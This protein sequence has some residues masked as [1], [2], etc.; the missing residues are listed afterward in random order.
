MALNADHLAA[1]WAVVETGSYH[2]AAETLFIT[3]SAV[4][5]RIQGLEAALG[6]KVFVRTGRRVHLTEAGRVLSRHCQA[7]RQL[8]ATLWETLAGHDGRLAGRLAVLAD[9][10]EWRGWLL[11]ALADLARTH[12][13]L[14][15]Q[16]TVAEA[17]DPAAS[18][19]AGK[20]DLVV[21]ERPLARRGLADRV[22]GT[23]AY[24]LVARPDITESWP[25]APTAALLQS[26]RGVDFAPEDRL[27]RD[28]LALCLPESD[29]TGF[30]SHFVNSTDGILAW[31]LEGAGYAAL[32]LHLV[33]PHLVSGRLRRLYPATTM[34]R[35]IHATHLDSAVPVAVLAAG[36]L[37]RHLQGLASGGAG[38]GVS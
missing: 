24:G 31:V 21:G 33:Q 23:M 25:E 9:A 4:S 16:V 36:A 11:P 35:P 15:V 29:A 28:A 14:D 18:L 38:T 32:P 6:Q 20:V 10:V 3:Q 30:M 2:R 12:P 37:A 7:T 8:E 19:L 26:L 22:L 13:S 5:Q 17:V 1:F 34:R 27:L